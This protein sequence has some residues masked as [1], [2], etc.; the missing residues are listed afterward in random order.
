MIREYHNYSL[1]PHNTFGI[2]V[3]ASRFIEYD[4]PNELYELISSSR[5]EEPYL[6]IGQGSNLLFVKDFEGTMLHSRIKSIDITDETTDSV[7]VRVGA[8]VRWD[9]FVLWCV[10]NNWYGIE[11]LSYIPGETGAC[12]V[13]NIGAYGTEI[14]DFISNVETINF[15]GKK[16]TY[17]V[18]ECKYAYRYSIFKE[19]DR[20]DCFVTYVYFK[21]SKTPHYVLDY[22]TVREAVAKY[23]EVSLKIV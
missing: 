16:Q 12:A 11:N 7:G 18:E 13:Q 6:H 23:P 4:T 1:L 8:G 21:L 14:K 17:S 5:I 15:A 20:K 9:D 2:D 22:G 19:L 3:T 10:E